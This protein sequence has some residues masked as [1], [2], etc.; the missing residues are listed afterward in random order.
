MDNKE[1]PFQLKNIYN[2]TFLDQ[3]VQEVKQVYP[4]FDART[5]L[6]LVFD[7]KWPQLELKQRIRHISHC[8]RAVLPSVYAD[9][10]KVLSA[11]AQHIT[12]RDGDKLNFEWGI[13]PDFV[14]AFGVDEPDVSIPALETLTRL[15]S[16]E[17][18][19]RPFLLRYP[20][21]MY[22]QFLSW[23]DHSSPMVRRLASEG[24]RPRLPWGM[25]V[26]V[27]KRDPAPILLV[28]E[29]LKNDPAET[30]RRSVANNLNDISKEHP[31]LALSLAKAWYGQNRNTNWVV[32][33][34][35]RGMLKKGH[36]EA[37]QL[38]GFDSALSVAEVEILE[39]TPSVRI[40]DRLYF[41]F[42][43]KNTGP[44]PVIV[45][46]DYAIHYLT[47]T[48]KISR[49]V[50]KINSF[51]LATRQVATFEKNQRFQ[52]FTTRKHYPGSHCIEILVNGKIMASATF[53]VLEA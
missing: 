7:E 46:L 25:G 36:P 44:E 53:Q 26:P 28:L 48:G 42:A 35:M 19:V 50:F 8:F 29:K 21:R 10:L 1:T 15:S 11:T 47:S 31:D 4:V 33:H 16:A 41:S 24:F 5:F 18:A 40:G 38:F 39:L 13:L 12:Q 3:V 32:A 27:L 51:T 52:D 17:F 43:L 14:E 23:A 45:R 9:A 37:M 34:A 30:V 49:K 22:A 2:P 20:E 6:R